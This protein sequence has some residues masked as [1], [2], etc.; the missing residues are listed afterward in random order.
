MLLDELLDDDVLAVADDVAFELVE[1]VDVVP[2]DADTFVA[3][4][5]EVAL[6]LTS[7]PVIATA[8]VALAMPVAMRARR[9]G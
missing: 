5:V 6:S 2:V 3:L 1:F 8:A 4:A 9:A 7:H